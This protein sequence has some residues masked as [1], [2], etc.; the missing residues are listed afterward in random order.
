MTR[1]LFTAIGLILGGAL[2]H[3]ADAGTITIG[4]A[5][6][7]NC[8]PFMCNGSETSTGPS[9]TYQ[10]VYSAS[11]FSGPVS[12]AAENFLW[13]FAQSFGGNDTLLGGTYVFTLSTTSAP[14]NGLST[15]L[16]ANLG[17][18]A[19]Q[20]LSVTIAPGGVSFGASY[21]FTNTTPFDYNPASGNL[22]LQVA[23][24]NQDDVANG[25]GNSYVDAD[26]T[27]ALTSRAYTFPS[28]P[29]AGSYSDGSGLVTTFTYGPVSI[30]EPDPLLLTVGGLLLLI[31]VA[32]VRGHAAE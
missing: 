5:D 15:N 26:D 20:V 29:A 12:I 6:T 11:T 9:V 14:V 27:G 23:V 13:V 28:G 30:S 4:T 17:A 8:V 7:G 2:A 31:G 3:N 21:T 25:D 16:S 10:Q 22:L 19:A 18:D 32:R 1:A 24:S